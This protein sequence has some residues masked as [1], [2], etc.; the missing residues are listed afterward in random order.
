M[1]TLRERNRLR[2]RGDIAA[3]A[4]ELF[5]QQGYDATTIDQIARAAGVSSA[6]F[7]RHF[8][9]K[10]DVLFADEDVAAAEMVDRV[11]VRADRSFTVA[12][13]A[14]PVAELALVLQSERTM[15]L[16]HLVMTN[17]SLES[18]S[19]RMRLRWERDIARQFASEQGL[20]DPT[21]DHSLAAAAAVSCL[22]TALRYWDKNKDPTGLV[23]L[24][25]LSFRRLF[26]LIGQSR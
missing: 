6:T 20:E 7:S 21:I 17:R 24:V 5:E 3:A 12:A 8:P 4:F 14:G 13:L 9:N 16:T 2:A 25:E 23:E 10:E 1:P 19:L 26:D 22:S 15:R 18:R 11:A